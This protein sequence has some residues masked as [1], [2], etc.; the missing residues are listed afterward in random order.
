[1]DMSQSPPLTDNGDP[2]RTGTIAQIIDLSWLT[3]LKA[4]IG[5]KRLF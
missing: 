4:L 1:M 5:V 2:S 3:G